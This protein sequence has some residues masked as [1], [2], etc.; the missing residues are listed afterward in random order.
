MKLRP[1]KF[2]EQDQSIQDVFGEVGIS[3][4][5]T[6]E[7]MKNV[8]TFV[9]KMYGHKKESSID[10]VRLGIFLKKYKPKKD[11]EIISCAKK[12]RKLPPF[13]FQRS[14]TES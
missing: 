11:S 4:I 12:G 13:L 9:C 14:H 2:L 7:Q 6:E 3:Q 10:Y 1:L 5:I 8:E